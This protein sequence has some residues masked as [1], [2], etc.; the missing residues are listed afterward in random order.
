MQHN[1]YIL[2]LSCPDR[3]GIVYRVSGLLFELGC[4]ILDSQQFGD[5]ET[6][7]FFLRV[8]FDL[9]AAVAADDLRGRLNTLSADY[10]MDLK[11]HD[12]R[13]KER[14]L[15]MVSKQGHCLND[16]LFR[17]HSGHLHAEVAAIVSNHNDYAALA[18]S[19]GIP[20]HY[21]PVT[22][23]TKA[24]QEK[25][26]LKIVEQSNTDLVVLARYMQILSADMCRALNGRAINIHHSF[27]P[28]FKGARPYHQAHAR[29]V[30]IIG[31][32]A[33]YVTSDLDEGPII[34][35]DIE[36]VD[37]TMTAQD[38]TQ[39]GSDIESLVLSRAVRSHVEHRILLN[40]N[41]TVVFR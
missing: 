20:F 10:G 30:K 11:L 5:E 15:I 16:L 17:V 38:L 33:H 40:R 12:A 4:N 18:A 34:D 19:Y 7:Q 2:T 26:V 31:A 8:H 39:V 37:H 13:R 3:T 14:L 22:A 24:E 21:L 6:G 41:K 23:E 36:R 35:Q 27:L 28:S 1:D 25:Q 32:T 9:P 29:G